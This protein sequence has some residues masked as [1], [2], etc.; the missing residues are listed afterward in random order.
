MVALV[1]IVSA[2]VNKKTNSTSDAQ[3]VLN[4]S[5]KDFVETINRRVDELEADL[6]VK[7][8]RIALL[9]RVIGKLRQH[10]QILESLLRSQNIPIPQSPIDLDNVIEITP[11]KSLEDVE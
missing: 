8:K 7:D 9:H 3:K 10:I 2:F 5:F 6:E 1:G 11:G 4:E